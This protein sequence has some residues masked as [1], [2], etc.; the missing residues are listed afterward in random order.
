MR[1]FSRSKMCRDGFTLFEL[2]LVMAV[3]IAIMAISIPVIDTMFDDARRTAA[4]DMVKARLA[5]ARSQ[6][7]KDGVAYHFKIKP[8]TNQF[9]IEADGVGNQTENKSGFPREGE[10]PNKVV[11]LKKSDFTY[12]TDS[13]GWDSVVTFLPDGTGRE[14]AT[15]I[16][17]KSGI[18]NVLEF[19]A[20]TGTFSITETVNESFDHDAK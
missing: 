17:G 13:Q 14:D 20:I 12:E 10:L 15:L 8:D 18:E 4:S 7:I 1:H 3:L 2:V 9:R 5:D 6:A 11:F 16:Y 19:R